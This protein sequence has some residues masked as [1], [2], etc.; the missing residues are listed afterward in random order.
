ML[1]FILSE[2]ASRSELVGPVKD[3]TRRGDDLRRI[4][5]II[6][7]QCDCAAGSLVALG[8]AVASAPAL[9]TGGRVP[10]NFISADYNPS[11]LKK[12]LA[13]FPRR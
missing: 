2:Q 12:L 4:I 9:G 13:T 1:Q 5:I 7:L 6:T 10:L 8:A 11:L 3:P